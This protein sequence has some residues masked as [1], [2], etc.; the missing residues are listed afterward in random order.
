MPNAPLGFGYVVAAGAIVYQ[1]VKTAKAASRSVG[2]GSGSGT[3]VVQGGAGATAMLAAAKAI[4][5]MNLPYSQTIQSSGP[6]AGWRQDCSGFVSFLLNKYGGATFGDLTTDGYPGVM[7]PGQG[8][9]VTIWDLP[10]AG[11]AGHVIIDIL[12]QWFE[13]GGA[14]SSGPHQMSEAEVKAQ[15]GVSDLSQLGSGATPN[16][17]EPFYVKGS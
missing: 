5:A 10:N 8:S 9:Q 3:G 7:Q 16:G 2:T 11:N 4:S 13:S 17:F 6:L 15:L 12:G 14:S 1:G